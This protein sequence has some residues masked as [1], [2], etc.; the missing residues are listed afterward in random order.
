MNFEMTGEQLCEPRVLFSCFWNTRWINNDSVSYS[1]FDA[2]DKNG[3][4]N[5][6]GYGL[7]IWGKFLGDKMVKT[8][9]S[10]HVKTFASWKPQQ[11]KLFFYVLNKSN[12]DKQVE[13]DV[14]G[15]KIKSIS[16][17]WELAGEGPEDTK[18]VW[19]KASQ[20]KAKQVMSINPTSITVV[21]FDLE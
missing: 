10:V 15:F 17:S 3:N 14:K 7:M 2:L 6:N 12:Q 5:A 8:T 19:R 13:V 18:P 11:K 16:Q 21:E 4:F 20:L 1:A 9:S